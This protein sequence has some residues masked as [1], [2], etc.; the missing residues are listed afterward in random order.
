MEPSNVIPLFPGPVAEV[1]VDGATV[2]WVSGDVDL[3][4]EPRLSAA[5]THAV[6]TSA[7]VLVDFCGCGFMDSVGIAALLTAAH[8]AR[9]ADV[10]FAVASRPGGI[11][12]ALFDMVVGH[13]FF[14]SCDDR[15]AG[16]AALRRVS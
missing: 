11:P 15:A 16:L 4:S 13:T 2:V 5:L 6:D 14:A 3:A 10:R 8:R 1:R 7:A 9:A 12:R